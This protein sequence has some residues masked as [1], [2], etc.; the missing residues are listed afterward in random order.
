MLSGLLKVL[1]FKKKVFKF[2]FKDFVNVRGGTDGPL[3]QKMKNQIKKFGPNNV[4]VLTARMQESDVAIHGWL[5]SK[6]INIPM[7]N[8]TGLGNS[9]G[10]A[11]AMWMLDKFTEGYND[12]YFVD[13]A[14]SNVKAVK[15]VLDQLDIKSKVQQVISSKS[16]DFDRDFNE[17]LE[18]STGTEASKRFSDAKA[19][20]RGEGKGKFNIFIPP[21]AED[22]LGL[23][24]Q[25]LGKGKLGEK[26]FKFFKKTLIDP[27]NRAYRDL[28]K[29]K[30]AI[31][32]DFAA[33]K[34][35]MPDVKKI[36]FNTIGDSDFTYNDAIRVYLWDK[37]GFEIP[38][39]SKSDQKELVETVKNDARLKAFADMLSILSRQKD[40]YVPPT[41]TW[42][43]EDIRADLK[44]ATDKVG[45]K[46]FFAEFLENMK[47]IFSP[48]NMNKIEA[49][50]G[51]A[52][53][54][55]LE[56]MLY[57][58]E[59]GTN[60]SFGSNKLVNDFMNWINGSI[61]TTMFFNARSAVLQTL[62]MVNFINFQD[63]N[64][65]AAAKAF[66]NQ[67]Q[68]WA[69]FIMIFN[70]D[71]L[72]Q[73]RSGLNIDVNASELTDYISSRGSG[74]NKYKAAINY[75]LSKGF[76]PTQIADSFAIAMGGASFYRNRFNKYVKEG[77]SISQA[78]EKAFQDFQA[79]A[80][81]TQQSARPDMIS[82]QQASVLGRIILAF[83]NT[84]MQ[85]ARLMKKAMLDL[86][87]GRGDAK[88]NVSRIIYYG[89]VQNIIFYSLQTALF[90]MM[91]DDDD[92]DEKFDKKKER[93]LNGSI[94][95][96]LRGMGVQGAIVSTLK[97]MIRA[98]Y[99]EQQKSFNK[100][101]S[102]VIMEMVNL[103]PP[104]GIKLRKIRDAER[105]LRWEKDL[106]E[107]IPFYNLKNPAWEAGFSFTQ[108]LTNVP[109][110]RLHQKTV[111]MS[112][113]ISQD[114]EAW[115]RIALMMGWT[116]WNLGIEDKSK[117]RTS[118]KKR[119][120]RSRRKISY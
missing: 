66:A 90:A 21:G 102:A 34:K 46:Q 106:V 16:I 72:K 7:K 36:L 62:S 54:E 24:Y 52:F 61:G 116:K 70:S 9:T 29:A 79:I 25:F 75:L 101:E 39:I 82:Q 45:R 92:D 5:K 13:D 110:S 57:R 42:L 41:V 94:D 95:S 49:I 80:E 23:I 14:L 77:M 48:E 64:I 105:T 10:E 6:G 89:A 12:M 76:L 47:I 37:A 88:A 118:S 31:A 33:L 74:A 28:N 20:R 103:S 50:Y 59:N 97:N 114:M 15:N 26:Q 108:A 1:S 2:D 60:R 11:K 53:R 98:F 119:S 73:R 55:A 51:K 84:P 86:V 56:D 58:I 107:E 115:Q 63:N 65:F 99:K 40:G 27:L 69:D 18:E 85:Y 35:K 17:I 38:G 100:D 104:L 109:L 112:D 67:K 19:R 117:K 71:M 3:L 83:Q 93:V 43:S 120:I 68:F 78:K 87:N 91:F 32:N 111:N 8:I 113:A 30:Q 96:I 44:N 22:F 81:E 4:F